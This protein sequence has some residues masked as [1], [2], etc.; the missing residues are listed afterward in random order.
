MAPASNDGAIVLGE[1]EAPYTD[2]GVTGQKNLDNGVG[3]TTVTPDKV[4]PG[5]PPGNGSGL[6]HGGNETIGQYPGER[7]ASLYDHEK[8]RES[9]LASRHQGTGEGGVPGT[10]AADNS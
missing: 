8:A 2:P 4:A 6:M 1:H 10:D 9:E 5:T 3:K 7:A